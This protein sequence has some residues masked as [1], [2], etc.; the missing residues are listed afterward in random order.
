MAHKTMIGGTVYDITGGK[1]L[2]GG[3]IY[4]VKKGIAKIN[5]TGYDIEFSPP[6]F[7]VTNIGLEGSTASTYYCYYE[8]NGEKYVRGTQEF[9]AGTKIKFFVDDRFNDDSGVYLNG[10]Q[11]TGRKFQESVYEYA[12][13]RNIRV[14]IVFNVYY[15]L[16]KAEIL[17]D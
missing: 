16:F 15:R 2:V 4:D 12:L 13:N 14:N 8:A 9:K 7:T 5:G 6:K 10:V 17:E 3:T 1:C 11:I